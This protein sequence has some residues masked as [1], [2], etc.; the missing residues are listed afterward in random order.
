MQQYELAMTEDYLLQMK[1]K[2]DY[3]P[4]KEGLL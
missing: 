1:I 2:I 3:H 4:D